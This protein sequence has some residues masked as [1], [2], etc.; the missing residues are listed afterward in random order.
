M[1]KA[2]AAPA[3]S[4]ASKGG[5]AQ[6]T[7]NYMAEENCA[8]A[9]AALEASELKQTQP[10]CDLVGEAQRR[11]SAHLDMVKQVERRQLL[12]LTLATTRVRHV[13]L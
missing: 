8:C 13:E 9:L 5:R 11:Y 1:G 7:P 12:L 10:V 4:A 3:A 2:K 6:G